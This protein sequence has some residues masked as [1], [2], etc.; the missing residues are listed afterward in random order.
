MTSESL[1]IIGDVYALACS[2]WCL[3]HLNPRVSA[4]ETRTIKGHRSVILVFVGVLSGTVW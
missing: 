4:K 3:T 1:I 2:V